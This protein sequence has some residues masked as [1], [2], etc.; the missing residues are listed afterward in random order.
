MPEPSC[1]KQEARKHDARSEL[2]AQ[3]GRQKELSQFRKHAH[4]E[5]QLQEQASKL[6]ASSAGAGSRWY[7]ETGTWYS[8]T[9]S[10]IRKLGFGNW[11]SE[12][13]KWHSE[14]ELRKRESGIR[15]L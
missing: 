5:G 7:S 3:E 2:A 11:Y 8:E 6:A 13:G 15:K 4:E 1:K 9:G 14:T 12:S 10:G